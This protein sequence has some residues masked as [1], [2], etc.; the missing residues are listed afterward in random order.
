MTDIDGVGHVLMLAKLLVMLDLLLLVLEVVVV[1]VNVAVLADRWTVAGI[2]CCGGK[3]VR[4]IDRAG[5]DLE[6][7]GCCSIVGS[8]VRCDVSR[9]GR[10]GDLCELVATTTIH[11]T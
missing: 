11:P 1:V 3:A 4:L 7:H 10:I 8:V 5:N 6:V 2:N 9:V